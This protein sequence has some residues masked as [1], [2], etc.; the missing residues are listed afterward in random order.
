MLSLSDLMFLVPALPLIAAIVTAALGPRVLKEA[1]HWPVI[2]GIGVSLFASFV[3]LLQVGGLVETDP[4]REG[5]G[6][7][8]HHTFWQ[9]VT[10]TDAMD[11]PEHAMPATG[12]KLSRTVDFAIGVTLRADSLTV[13]MLLTV[14]F[15][16]LLVAIYSV[17]YM[18]GDPGYWRFFSLIGLF[19][20]SMTMLVSASNFVMLYVFWEA[21]GV[22]SYLLIGFWYQK[23]SAAEAGKKA[24]LVNRVGDFGFAIGLF[25]LW[26]TYGTLNFHDADGVAGIL[27]ATRLDAGTATAYVSGGLGFAICSCL[28]IGACGKSAQFPLHVWLPDAMEGP[29]PVSALIHAA[30]MVTAGV[31]MIVRCTPLFF[32]SVEAQQVVAVVGAF[33]ALLAGLI[34][35]TQT[36]LKR[37]LAYSTVSQ[38]GFMFLS[39]GTGSTIGIMAGMFHLFTHAFFK[40]LL[41]LGSGSV[42]HAM[43]NVIDMRHFGGLR[44]LMP[45]TCVTFCIGS[46]A[47]AGIAPLAGF[48]SKD[49]IL[50]AVHERAAHPLDADLIGGVSLFAI[51][52]WSATLTAFLT[53]FY[54]FR[55]FFKTFFGQQQVPEEAG[56]HA[57]ESPRSMTVP[58]IVL[59]AFALAI[60]AIM[61]WSH[62]LF[63]FLATTPSLATAEL[64][65][66]P[67]IEF[68]GDVALTSTIVAVCGVGLAAYFYLGEQNQVER[69]ARM[70]GPLYRLSHRK[71]Y[72][73]EIYIGFVIWPLR[74]V[75][76]ICYLLDRLLIDGLVNLVGILPPM[77]GAPMRQWQAGRVPSYAAGMAW[78]VLILV[79]LFVLLPVI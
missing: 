56:D 79:L 39:L 11:A 45:I 42:M 12:T 23:P 59:S 71:F 44:K 22:C 54:T 24:F 32:A 9:W 6:Y 61:H 69:I 47:L 66:T 55:A 64:S 65:K 72:F 17:G 48:W 20:F 62:W 51:L 35:V 52:Y 38:L 70:L 28:L 13:I 74:A 33:T 26:T 2:V 16:S 8:Q 25:L 73:D 46:L 30:T 63:D 10:V 1:S 60:G 3:L 78:G 41:F 34:A 75:A 50:G 40:A 57:H 5:P 15:V 14:T 67:Q 19:V 31:Y 58:L 21:V 53:A 4:A 49:M 68:H 77:I 43:G 36:D 7:A 29:T 27:G 76:W 18:R 37:V